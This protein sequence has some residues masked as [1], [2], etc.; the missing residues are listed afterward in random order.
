MS[1]SAIVSTLRTFVL[2]NEV[3][4]WFP[5]GIPS[6]NYLDS[7]KEEADALIAKATLSSTVEYITSE[8]LT[9]LAYL[10]ERFYSAEMLAFKKEIINYCLEN[11]YYDAFTMSIPSSHDPGYWDTFDLPFPSIDSLKTVIAHAR[12]V[13]DEG[14]HK[15]KEVYDEL[16]DSFGEV[17]SV[18]PKHMIERYMKAEADFLNSMNYM[19]TLD[20][21]FYAAY[22]KA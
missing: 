7:L 19:H 5:D 10:M 18:W 13:S 2:Q 21:L 8:C 4:T 6:K 12:K 22:T 3:K 16:T 17:I 1:V 9:P 15:Y 14:V 11:G 20:K